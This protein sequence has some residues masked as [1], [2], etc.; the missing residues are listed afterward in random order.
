MRK[1]F[2]LCSA[3][4]ISLSLSGCSATWEEIKDAASGIN[5]AADEAATAISQDVHS[6][7]AADITY[8]GR[9]FTIN[10]LF[11][12]I[13]RDVQWH[14]EQKEGTKALKVTGT[15]QPGLFAP[16]GIPEEM[17]EKLAVD[18]EATILLA[19]ENNIIQEEE[20]VATLQYYGETI[21]AEEGQDILHHLYD[22]YTAK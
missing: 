12:S 17:E 8:N 4:I 2:T 16:F 10:D 20:T 13:L 7:R 19:V 21:V 18:G 11:K 15:W 5:T 22:Q 1:L 6:I 14:Y 3:C 9:T